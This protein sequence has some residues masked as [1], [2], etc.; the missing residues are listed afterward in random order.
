MTVSTRQNLLDI[1]ARHMRSR[2]YAAFSYG[3]LAAECGIRKA[4]VH[5]HFPTKEALGLAVL[6]AHQEK[7]SARLQAITDDAADLRERLT[8]YGAL[9]REG[10]GDGL[11]PLCGALAAERD[12]LPQAMRDKAA[13]LLRVQLDWLTDVLAQGG[14]AHAARSA[15]ALLV[16]LEGGAIVGWG[17]SGVA[18]GHPFD[19]LVAELCAS[20]CAGAKGSHHRISH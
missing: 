1:A 18:S 14:V 2:G 5:H 16:A 13:G 17:L 8:A 15:M 11:L 19:D 9:F 7:F 12:A 6:D 20:L 10:S 4:S 3:D